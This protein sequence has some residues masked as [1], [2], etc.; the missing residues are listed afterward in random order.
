[1]H[2]SAKDELQQLIDRLGIDLSFGHHHA[3]IAAVLEERLAH[4]M[5]DKALEF[6]S[7]TIKA[8]FEAAV[9]GLTRVF[10]TDARVV[11]MLRL[12]SLI[13]AQAGSFATMS[14]ADV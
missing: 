10:D 8:H 7:Y 3:C 9:L 4:D 1:M 2:S 11:S 12:P 14:S 13:E 6:W 5:W